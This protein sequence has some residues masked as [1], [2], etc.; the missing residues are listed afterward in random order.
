MPDSYN[1]GYSI[2][3]EKSEMHNLMNLK[4]K[5][6]FFASN[7]IKHVKFASITLLLTFLS[8]VFLI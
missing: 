4:C 7:P 3:L 6:M 1:L 2:S 5:S 8:F